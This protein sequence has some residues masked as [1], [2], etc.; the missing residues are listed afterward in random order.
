MEYN[1]ALKRKENWTR[2]PWINLEDLT[3]SE[4]SLS[5]KDKYCIIPLTLILSGI[6][7]VVAGLRGKGGEELVF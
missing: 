1:S 2:I 4:I 5:Q 6:G 7:M 3:L